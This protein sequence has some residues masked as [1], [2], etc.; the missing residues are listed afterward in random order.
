MGGGSEMLRR[1]PQPK[2]TFLM[3]SRVSAL[4]ALPRARRSTVPSTRCIIS[5]RVSLFL[6]SLIRLASAPLD[7]FDL[8]APDTVGQD[9]ASR[10]ELRDPGAAVVPYPSVVPVQEH[11]LPRRPGNRPSSEPPL[12][13][14]RPPGWPDSTTATIAAAIARISISP[15][16]VRTRGPCTPRTERAISPQPRRARR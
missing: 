7:G 14:H 9:Q 11:P 16:A 13:D 15:A 6:T 5:T 1:R 8:G 3:W 12:A 4:N 10:R 2:N